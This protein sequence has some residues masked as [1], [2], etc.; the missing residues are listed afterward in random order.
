LLILSPF[1]FDLLLFAFYLFPFAFMK[2]YR[3]T[4]VLIGLF[5]GGLLVLWWLEYSGVP[6]EAERQL[7]MGRVLPSLIDT[8]EAAIHRVEVEREGKTLAFE[9]RGKDR[10]QMVEPLDVSADATTLETL[11]RNLRDL[12]RS[13]DTGP[14]TGPGESYGL[15]PPSSVVRLFSSAAAASASSS[16]PLAALEIGKSI[17]GLSYVRTA[18]SQA[19]DVVDTKLL[20]F[21][22][23]SATEWRELNLVPIPTFQVSGLTIDRGGLSVR[24]DRGTGGRWRLTKPVTVPGNGPK[25]EGTLAA[26]SSI[27][28]VDGAKG[29]IADNV[30]DFAPYGLDH[31]DAKIEL[32]M[33]GRSDEPLVLH[34]GKKPPDHPD[35]V[36]VRRGDQND[37]VA[38][39]DRFLTEIPRDSTALR[40]QNVADI[41]P[42]EISEIRIEAQKTAFT[43]QRQRDGWALRSPRAEKADSQLVQSL[44]S[45]LDSLKASEFLRADR[46]L[47]P[48]LDPP[49]MTI[50]AWQARPSG[51]SSVAKEEA[52]DGSPLRPSVLSLRIGRHDR[53]KKTV[54]GQIEGDDVILALPDLLLDHLPKNQHAFRDRGVLALSPADVSKLTLSREGTTTILEPDR[55]SKTPNRWRMTAPVKAAADVQAITQLLALFSDLRA[56]E[57]VADS[58]GDGKSFGLDQPPITVAWD[59]ESASSTP[60]KLAGTSSAS[61][62]SGRLK[63]GK[64]VVGKPGTFFATVDGQPFVFTLAAAAIQALVAEFHDTQVLSIPADAI[65]RLVFRL[66]GKSLAFVRSLEHRGRPA[67]WSAEPGTDPRG[68]DLSRFNDL[69]TQLAQLR[70]P[71]FFQYEGPITAATGLIRPRLMLEFHLAGG[72]PLQVLRIGATQ[73]GAVLA[74]TGTGHS[75]PV[76]YL[77]AAAWDALILSVSPH[78]DL[79]ENVFAP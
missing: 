3:P 32:F 18:G 78:L 63:I 77:P 26:L 37:V 71:R 75:G 68:I 52:S 62:S 69:V 27:R 4:L 73:G 44:L 41:V 11:V 25:I 61:R 34:V 15:A 17:H 50:K 20:S 10:W 7:R 39:S 13:P 19:I 8:A 36:Y 48:D 51:S 23:R 66:P 31:P 9:R 40:A 29:F 60:P 21:V 56:L 67:D 24:A 74:A 38:V 46:V 54:Y 53:L 59:T 45:Q 6:T 22:D 14:I 47:R 2:N 35:R 79:P 16:S 43:L 1:V 57:F 30:S 28:V 64:P 70:T 42:G 33:P 49:V 65:R 58:V 72:N 55:S 5:F 76:I 12:R